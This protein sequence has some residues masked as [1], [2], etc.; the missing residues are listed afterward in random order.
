MAISMFLYGRP[1]ELI[2]IPS[3]WIEFNY[4]PENVSEDNFNRMLEDLRTFNQEKYVSR[5]TTEG[6]HLMLK[7]KSST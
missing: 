3:K 7:H 6:I 5:L 1:S 2:K 4:Y